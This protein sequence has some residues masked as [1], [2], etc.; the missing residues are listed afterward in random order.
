MYTVIG[1]PLT[2]TLRVLWTLEELGL[3]YTHDPARPRSDTVTALNATGK[4]PVLVTDE[5][6][7][8]DSI[9]IIT[10]LADANGKLTAPAGTFA[11]ARQDSVMN[12]ILTEVDAPLWAASKHSFVLPEDKR[13]SGMEETAQYEFARAMKTLEDM[14]GDAPFIAG[15]EFTI[16][17]IVLS[18]CAG[19]ALSR[20]FPLPGGDFGAYLKSLRKRPAMQRL[21]ARGTEKS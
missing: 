9:A 16:A 1:H 12:F 21:L 17:D 19:W 10:Y 14:K 8:S 15:A 3:D 7:I 13:L 6:P 18:H 5:G 4:V 11:R 20:K 2:R